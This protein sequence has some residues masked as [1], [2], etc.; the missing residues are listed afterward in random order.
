MYKLLPILLFS[1]FILAQFHITPPPRNKPCLSNE[2]RLQ[3]QFEIKNNREML[4]KNNKLNRI[5][6]HNRVLFSQPIKASDHY[7]GYSNYV[8]Y[9]YVSHDTNNPDSL[10]DWNCGSRTYHNHKG[11]DF[12][13]SPYPWNMMENN[14]VEVISVADGII[15]ANGKVDNW[16][17]DICGIYYNYDLPDILIDRW[18]YIAIEHFDGTS[19][20]YGHLRTNSLTNKLIGDM[21]HQGEYLGIVGS[22]GHSYVPHLHFEVW[23][24]FGTLLDPFYGECNQLNN[25]SLWLNQE[26]YYKS[27]I[28]NIM[29][30][31]SYP[32]W[33]DCVPSNLY[34]AET[35]GLGSIVYIGAYYRDHFSGQVS[36]WNI[37]DQLGDL[38]ADWQDTFTYS[39]YWEESSKIFPITLPIE[40]N[41][42]GNWKIEIQFEGNNYEKYF[43]VIDELSNKT[44]FQIIDNYRIDRPYPNPFNPITNIKYGIPEY[45]NVQIIIFDLTGKQVAL[46]INE[47][48][49]PGYHS[50]NW[51]AD[52]LPSGVYFIRMDSGDFTQ[53][54]KVVLVK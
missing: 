43:S 25:E 53:T 27:S 32:E 12:A 47:F 37:Y 30:H 49:S 7:Q 36:N 17:D 13:V 8:I 21:V 9:K 31:S 33:N 46:L 29:T 4:I 18:N 50:V 14:S 10:L 39:N 48:Q 52:N 40:P 5:P 42:I 34:N 28:L 54:Q 45:S 23:N 24:Q 22:S 16:P 20:I 11:T 3:M 38:Y 15:M 26:S 35:F 6:I 1:T 41:Y 51:D 2:N 44:D 19:A